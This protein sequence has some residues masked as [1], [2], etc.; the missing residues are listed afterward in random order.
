MA[1]FGG[2]GD[3]YLS[4]EGIEAL[5]RFLPVFWRR[6]PAISNGRIGCRIGELCYISFVVHYGQFEVPEKRIG[7]TYNTLV[8]SIIRGII[9]STG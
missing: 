5:W 7:E 2:F 3:I 9:W 6:I 4:P 1:E 8:V